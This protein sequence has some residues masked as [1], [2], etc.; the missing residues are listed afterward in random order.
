MGSGNHHG[1]QKT[2]NAKEGIDLLDLP[3]GRNTLYKKLVENGVIDE[4]HRPNQE[5][6]SR[7]LMVCKEKLV[8]NGRQLKFHNIPL[9]TEAGLL[10]AQ[11]F[12]I[13]TKL[14]HEQ[15]P[16]NQSAR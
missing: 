2:Y 11:D 4:E 7:G 8:G 16:K 14:E 6:V 3:I 15:K 5:M 12:F 13:E 10:F 9:F 1:G